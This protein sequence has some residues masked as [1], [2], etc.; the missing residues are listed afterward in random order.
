MKKGDGAGIFIARLGFNE[1]LCNECG[2]KFTTLVG[3]GCMASAPGVMQSRKAGQIAR[4]L[5]LTIGLLCSQS[6]DDALFDMLFHAQCNIQ[7]QDIPPL[8]LTRAL[9]I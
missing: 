7:R 8:T 2:N 1:T 5:A 3:M 9:Q 6:F 4:R